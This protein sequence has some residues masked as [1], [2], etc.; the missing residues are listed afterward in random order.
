MSKAEL[1]K[2]VKAYARAHYNENNWDAIVECYSDEELA[3]EIK[4]NETFHEVI[5]RMERIGK[6]VAEIKR[7]RM[8]EANAEYVAAGELPF[9]NI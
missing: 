1:V 4:D 5:D 3:A 9:W 7:D 8:A 2:Q 6:V